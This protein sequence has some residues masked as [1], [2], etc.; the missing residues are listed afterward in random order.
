MPLKNVRYVFV[1]SMFY[2]I[3]SYLDSSPCASFFPFPFS[4]TNWIQMQEWTKYNHL[5]GTQNR[6]ALS[7]YS[8][9]SMA[10]SISSL[11]FSNA[12]MGR[13]D[14]RRRGKEMKLHL[15][16]SFCSCHPQI[17]RGWL[18]LEFSAFNNPSKLHYLPNK[19]FVFYLWDFWNIF[20]FQKYFQPWDLPLF[21]SIQ[22]PNLW[23]HVIAR[24]SLLH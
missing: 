9:I 13:K 24:Q 7:G 4:H 18:I 20:V 23:V 16:S 1:N 22:T 14:K 12:I 6:R 15:P 2:Y 21:H 10:L 19:T 17:A 11:S 8:F 3:I 5:R